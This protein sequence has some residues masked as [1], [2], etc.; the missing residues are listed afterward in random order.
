MVF[1]CQERGLG[2]ISVKV[3]R[4]GDVCFSRRL[5]VEILVKG[6]RVAVIATHG[7]TLL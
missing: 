1:I 6:G 2:L 4:V 5:M 7:G 3:G